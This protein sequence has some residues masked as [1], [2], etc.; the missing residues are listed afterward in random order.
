MVGE[1]GE[2]A[3]VRLDPVAHRRTRV[4][5]ARGPDVERADGEAPA[6]R[7]VQL[8]AAWQIAQQH[9]KQGRGEVPAEARLQ[10]QRGAGRSP[11][12]DLHAGVVERTE[13]P[14]PDD[15]VHVKVGQQHVHPGKPR[16]QLEREGSD[17]RPRVEHEHGA[18][19][20]RHAHTRGVAA[21][22]GGGRPRRRQGASHA[23]GRDLHGPCRSQNIA[24]A[25]SRRSSWSMM[26]NAV[27]STCSRT[28]SPRRSSQR[29]A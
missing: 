28:R 6:A 3:L 21:V 18:I 16:G 13:E 12:V 11:D 2:R 15:V 17:T 5:D 4:A 9:R 19:R 23:V 8:E 1:I 27:S 26:G 22:A 29:R 25:P 24:T 20:P 7:V 10:A 14:Q